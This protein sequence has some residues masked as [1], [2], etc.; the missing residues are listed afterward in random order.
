MKVKIILLFQHLKC[1]KD[2]YNKQ[3]QKVRSLKNITKENQ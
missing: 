2:K 1:M 3:T